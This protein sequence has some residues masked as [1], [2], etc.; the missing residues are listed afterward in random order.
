MTQPV[1]CITGGGSGIGYGTAE[2]LLNHQY[3]VV[4]CGRRSSVIET[5]VQQLRQ[6]FPTGIISGVVADIATESG[7]LDLFKHIQT[8][9][10]RL[11]CLINNASTLSV[12]P[13][14]SVSTQTIQT[15]INTNI[16]STILCSQ[17]A[18][19]LLKQSPNACIVNISSLGGIQGSLKFPGFSIY[20]MTKG[21]VVA[22][23]E[24][25]AVELK[26]HGIRVN[27]L[28]PG[29]VDTPMLKQAGSHLSTDTTPGDIAP[30]ILFLIQASPTSGLSG[31]ILE[32]HSNA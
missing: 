32:V 2:L 19:P 18:I 20:S 16:M 17:A 6:K 22:L 21:A 9:H 15:L 13:F 3:A 12:E 10:Q 30:S 31:T 27:A 11:D 26:P 14:E 4:I 1:V 5:A 25:L 7:V 29:A 8:H 23:T 24:T 28:A